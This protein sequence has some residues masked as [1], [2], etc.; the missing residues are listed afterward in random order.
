MIVIVAPYSPPS[1]EGV[2]HLGA[3]RKL[4]TIISILFRL[5]PK[6]VL[7][8]SAHNQKTPTPLT[9]SEVEIC[10]VAVIEVTPQL[11]ASRQFGKFKNIFH[12]KQILDVVQTLG[13]P[14]LFWFYNGYAFEMRFAEIAK[15]KFCV[16]M[17]FE[18]EDWH[19]SRNR[20]FS[21]KPYVDYFFW[22][23]AVVL[24][25]ESFVVNKM[26]ASKIEKFIKQVH[27]LPGIVPKVLS[28]I[29]KE[30]QPFSIYSDSI[31]IGFFGGLSVEKGADLILKLVTTLPKGYV[32]HVTGT[33]V[34]AADFEECAKKNP[35][36]LRYYGRVDD[37]K[38][39]QLI[40]KCDVMLNPHSSIDNMS[41]G[42]FPFK[43]IEAIAS[44]RLLI[45]TAVP[46]DGLEDV[47]QG[48]HFV[49]H[50][51]NAFKSA[52]FSCRLHYDHNASLIARGADIANQR[53]GEDT[54][55]DRVKLILNDA[56]SIV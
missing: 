40:S 47:L 2:A 17:I 39:Y 9:I 38:L 48:V 19:F 32:L 28:N 27:I 41:N 53:F 33:G 37:A 1:R 12:V 36:I 52:I 8:N 44:G 49:E 3:S 4:E 22:R 7:I 13:I 23:R 25:S 16:P 20:G 54:L 31:H 34:L 43:V 30:S 35:E 45:S 26:I 5:D 15:Y 56:R 55:L 11:S 21:L 46:K 18:F 6:I 50:N 14:Q 24:M 29:A 51:I 10:G 42:V